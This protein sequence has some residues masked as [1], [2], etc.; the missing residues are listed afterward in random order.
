[1]KTTA[2]LTAAA[3]ALFAAPV[4]ACQPVEGPTAN[5]KWIVAYHP[6]E[7]NIASRPLHHAA[8]GPPPALRG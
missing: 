7:V 8:H 1:M 4:M 2:I 6:L 3:A 5:G